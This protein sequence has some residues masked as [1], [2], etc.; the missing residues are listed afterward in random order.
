MEKHKA[1]LQKV[2]HRYYANNI[3]CKDLHT[4]PQPWK[5]P[6]PGNDGGIAQ[7][8]ATYSRDRA[9]RVDAENMGD[10]MS[11]LEIRPISLKDANQ[12]VE[13]NHRHHRKATG[14]KFSLSAWADDKLHGVAIVG[15]PLSRFLDDGQTLEVLRL[16]TDGT[17]NAC[18]ILYAR[19]AKIA[20]D[21]GYK[22]IITYILE[23]EDGASVKASGWTLEAD[24][25]G[26][27]RLDAL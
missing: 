17:Y 2:A 16:C 21:M 22:K 5:L 27:G 4:M 20:R 7:R 11:H 10:N 9:P 6:A 15:R 13:D 1:P 8:M 24:E 3:K 18:S 14:H 23:E 26:G 12:Y 25:V 19:C